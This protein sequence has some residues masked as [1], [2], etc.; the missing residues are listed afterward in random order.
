[1][2]QRPLAYRQGLAQANVL[3][4][5][6]LSIQGIS[7]SFLLYWFSFSVLCFLVFSLMLFPGV[8]QAD[9]TLTT[10]NSTDGVLNITGNGTVAIGGDADAQQF[11]T[12]GEGTIDY[13]SLCIYDNGGAPS[14][15][16]VVYLYAD[17]GG[18]PSGAS[19]G[20]VLID[21]GDISTTHQRVTSL[22]GFGDIS[23]T[24]ST[25][26]WL[27]STQDFD[28][29]NH[30]ATCG[31]S[32]N[33]WPHKYKRND[34]FVSFDGETN[35]TFDITEGGGVP[36]DNPGSGDIAEIFWQ[37]NMGIMQVLCGCL[38]S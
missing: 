38:F 8:A 21:S 3:P 14:S 30:Y 36:V 10:N 6:L 22:T 16:V 24:A 32:G 4:I 19:L 25:P 20:S 15:D 5:G 33:D 37:F 34:G 35:Y 1:M 18:S 2:E 23:L 31:N 29:T 12:T 13:I 7:F 26:Y 28:E 17:S 27:L 9:Y 11:T